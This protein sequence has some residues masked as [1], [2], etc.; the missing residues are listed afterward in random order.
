[1]KQKECR[2]VSWE[3]S[4]IGRFSLF[5]RNP[6]KN[7]TTDDG[8]NSDDNTFDQSS[9]NPFTFGAREDFTSQVSAPV[10]A[11]TETLVGLQNQIVGVSDGISAQAEPPLTIGTTAN[12]SAVQF[13]QNERTQSLAADSVVVPTGGTSTV[14]MAGD[15]AS[16]YVFSNTVATGSAGITVTVNYDA[17]VNN[18]P[19]G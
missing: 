13:G 18:A 5:S 6:N 3:G 17:S 4:M 8:F 10:A 12:A 14:G 16:S 11:L 1:S 7:S 2:P 9:D 19:N 15:G